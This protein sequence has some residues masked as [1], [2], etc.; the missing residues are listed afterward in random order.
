MPPPLAMNRMC[1]R[2]G[3]D[4]FRSYD[5]T[6]QNTQK[7]LTGKIKRCCLDAQ[8]ARRCLARGEQPLLPAPQGPNATA[9]GRG[10]PRTPGMNQQKYRFGNLKG[11][12]PRSG[13]G[14]HR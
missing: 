11:C 1:F 6:L 5:L 3:V 8:V 9:R 4:R 13:Y 2:F 14:R 7:A 10:T 12:N